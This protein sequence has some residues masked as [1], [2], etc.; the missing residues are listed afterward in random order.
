MDTTLDERVVRKTYLI[1]FSFVDKTKSPGQERFA[2]QV[3]EA[4]DSTNE[5]NAKPKQC[6]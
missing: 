3:I 5:S 2:A 6:A 4:F 1:T